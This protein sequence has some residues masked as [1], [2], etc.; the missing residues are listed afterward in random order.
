M[1][2]FLL[3]FRLDDAGCLECWYGEKWQG[4]KD[5]VFIPKEEFVDALIKELRFHADITKTPELLRTA[6]L[7]EQ[8]SKEF[9]RR[10]G[11]LGV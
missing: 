4:G 7:V 10:E 9:L 6:G 3:E 8:G 2:K 1:A 5:K 11:L